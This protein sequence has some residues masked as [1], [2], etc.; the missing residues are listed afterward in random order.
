MTVLVSIPSG[1][2]R[3]ERR[4]LALWRRLDHAVLRR[5]HADP[6]RIAALIARRTSLPP[7]AIRELLLMPE[8]SEEDTR[9]WFG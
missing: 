4:A 8:V 9:T 6:D 5:C 7:E 2:S 1:V 3:M